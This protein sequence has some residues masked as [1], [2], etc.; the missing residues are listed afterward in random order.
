MKGTS[1]TIGI[2]VFMA[3]LW[4]V[5]GSAFTADVRSAILANPCA[6][7][8]GT[9]GASPGSIPTLNDLESR[10]IKEAM[11]EFKSGERKSSIMGRI[12]KGYTDEEI[13]L[14]AKHFK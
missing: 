12:A 8:H 7:C 13:A 2:A 6:G 4:F 10:D 11:M 14:I 9:D 3:L 5:P 1:S